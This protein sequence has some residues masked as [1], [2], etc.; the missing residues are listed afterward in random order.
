MTM[1][2]LRQGTWKRRHV[3]ATRQQPAITTQQ[4]DEERT[5]QACSF[6]AILGFEEP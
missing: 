1:E 3:P 4:D 6:K 5:G 2:M